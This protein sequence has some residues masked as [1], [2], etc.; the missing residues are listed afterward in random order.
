MNNID[1]LHDL[2]ASVGVVSLRKMFGGHGI[3]SDGLMFGIVADGEVF[4][5]VDDETR[6]AF[7]KAGSRPFTYLAKDKSVEMAY[8]CLPD[9][10]ADDPDETAS[11]AR[12]AK[13]AAMRAQAVKK[14]ATKKRG[15]K[16]AGVA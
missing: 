12:L 16:G 6:S 4:L 15:R 11:W 13:Q 1:Y 10:A 2:F 3:Y 7:E 8:W 14:T 9:S 5:K